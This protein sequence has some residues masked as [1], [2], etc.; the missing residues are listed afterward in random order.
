MRGADVKYIGKH[1]RLQGVDYT[2]QVDLYVEI[3]QTFITRSG[4]TMTN[5]VNY[6]NALVTAANVAYEAEI[7]K[8]FSGTAL[9]P[10]VRFLLDLSS[11]L[12][13]T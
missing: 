6:V 9:L 5:A 3:D 1:R 13:L 4:G 10:V 8:L 12:I 2:Y 7:G 11:V